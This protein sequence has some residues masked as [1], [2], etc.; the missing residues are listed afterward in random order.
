MKNQNVYLELRKMCRKYNNIGLM[1]GIDFSR[2]EMTIKGQWDLS[3]SRYEIFHK[4]ESFDYESIENYSDDIGIENLIDN[5]K[6]K[7]KEEIEAQYKR[8]WKEIEGL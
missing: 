5:F 4:T 1:I 8:E 2:F 3:L 7:F 6:E